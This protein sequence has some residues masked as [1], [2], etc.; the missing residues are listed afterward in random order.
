MTWVSWLAL[1][2]VLLT[3]K[4]RRALLENLKNAVMQA[5]QAFSFLLQSK[6]EAL[7]IVSSC[8]PLPLPHK[9]P[10]SCSV[11]GCKHFLP[12]KQPAEWGRAFLPFSSQR[13]HRASVIAPSHKAA[14]SLSTIP[15]NTAPTHTHTHTTSLANHFSS[16][17]VLA[18]KKWK[19]KIRSVAVR[20]PAA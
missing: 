5:A 17:G 18:N 14:L 7:L 8:E 10:S 6:E 11:R 2:S 19:S 4:L 15:S 3:D 13:L 16:R 12:H 1:L 20:D 9:S